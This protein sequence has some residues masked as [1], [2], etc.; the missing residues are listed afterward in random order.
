MIPTRSSW[1][2]SAVS[3]ARLYSMK[4]ANASHVPINSA[5]VFSSSYIY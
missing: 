1:V 2:H 4:A 5:S 3:S